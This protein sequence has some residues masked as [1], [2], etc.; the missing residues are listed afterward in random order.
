MHHDVAVLLVRRRRRRLLLLL[1]ERRY[2][3]RHE[4]VGREAPRIDQRRRQWGA[5]NV[6]TVQD[7]VSGVKRVVVA[8]SALVRVRALDVFVGRQV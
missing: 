2:P 3:L 1:V 4:V 8:V 5:Q 7:P 6:V